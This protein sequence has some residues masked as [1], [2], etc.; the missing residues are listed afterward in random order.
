MILESVK[1][2]PLIW[3]TIEENRVTRTK[4]YAELSATE[5]IQA[6]FNQQS[7]LVEF[8]QIDP[9]VAVLG[10]P[11]SYAAGTLGTRAKTSGTRGNNSAQ[12]NGKVLNKEEL[13]FLADPGITE[14]PVTQTVITHNAGYQADDLD[15]YDSEC[16][17]ISTTKAVLVKS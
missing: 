17:G 10:I 3:S 16:D 5:K 13:E 7:H 2:S 6:D 15:A 12:G 1:H 11:N 4:K 8:P 9:G 14:G